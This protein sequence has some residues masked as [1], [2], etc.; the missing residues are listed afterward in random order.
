VTYADAGQRFQLGADTTVTIFSPAGDETSWNSNAA[1]IVL[2]VSY[3]ETDILLTGDAP[4]GTEEYLVEQYGTMLAAE[5]LKLGH[6]GSRTSTSDRLL[7]TVQPEYAIVSAS[8]DNRYN[9]PHPGVMEQVL[10]RGIATLQTGLEGTIT[11]VSDGQRITRR[12]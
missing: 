6:H 7:E 9:H 4:I 10:T 12:N 2:K 8:A 3:G 11:F 5:I 1:S